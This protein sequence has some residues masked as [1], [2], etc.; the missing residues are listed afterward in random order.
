MDRECSGFLKLEDLREFLANNGFFATERELQ[1][2][3]AKCDKNEDGRIS[4]A[5]FI[6]EFSPKLGH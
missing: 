1:T 4:F 2:I 6:D 3:M 5:E